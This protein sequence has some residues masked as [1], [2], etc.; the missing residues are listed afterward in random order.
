MKFICID[1]YEEYH[2]KNN[3]LGRVIPL[4][5]S[6]PLFPT[7]EHIEPHLLSFFKFHKILEGFFV[8]MLTYEKKAFMGNCELKEGGDFKM[9]IYF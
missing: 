9:E 1:I 4:V 6:M 3:L 5:D 2:H 8:F 7:K